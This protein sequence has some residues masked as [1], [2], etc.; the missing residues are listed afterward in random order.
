MQIEDRAFDAE[1]RTF[2]AS[3]GGVLRT[4]YGRWMAW[5][6][7][8]HDFVRDGVQPPGQINVYHAGEPTYTAQN[9]Y[10]DGLPPIGSA[11]G[12]PIFGSALDLRKADDR[13]LWRQA[14]AARPFFHSS[15]A[16]GKAIA[17]WIWDNRPDIVRVAKNEVRDAIAYRRRMSWRTVGQNHG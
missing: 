9:R 1:V 16:A 2:V 17:A 11:G 15:E 7:P 8:T 5:L 6:D 4:R 12:E 13:V 14:W 10:W 3:F